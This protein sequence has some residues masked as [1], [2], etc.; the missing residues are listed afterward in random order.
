MDAKLLNR[1]DGRHGCEAL[2]SILRILALRED[3]L[4]VDVERATCGWLTPEIVGP[5]KGE[6]GTEGW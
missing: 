6:S 5:V 1:P 4:A 3:A 2:A